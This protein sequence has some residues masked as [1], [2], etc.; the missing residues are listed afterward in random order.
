MNQMD[1]KDAFDGVERRL[2]PEVDRLVDTSIA[3]GAR[4][5]RRRRRG[6]ALAA[7]VTVVVVGVGGGWWLQRPAPVERLVASDAAPA[8]GRQR[9]DAAEIR[10]RLLAMLPDG[11]VTQVEVREDPGSGNVNGN[12][13]GIEVSL[14][15]DGTP[16]RLALSDFD[17][18][19][20]VVRARWAQEPGPRPEGCQ[21]TANPGL[22]VATT[23]AERDCA[24]WNES[25]R[26][27][28]C[29]LAP[30]CGELDKYV[31]YSPKKE[32]CNYNESFPCRELPDGSWLAAGAG[33][34]GDGSDSGSPFTMA[35]RFTSDGWNVY[36]S[37]DN[38]PAHVLTVDQVSAIVTSEAWFE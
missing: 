31:S 13:Q 2:R 24:M 14:R 7:L 36:A 15:L 19:P 28:D 6:T 27:R 35:N 32:V 29:A 18:D 4:Q 21:S 30:S 8:D 10:D 3:N 17:F 20:D 11:E 16:I 38:K 1:L 5:V 26:L 22:A 23:D 34:G 12:Q 25:N 33:S 9:A 37:A